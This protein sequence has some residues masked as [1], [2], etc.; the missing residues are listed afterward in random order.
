MLLPKPFIDGLHLIVIDSLK[1]SLINTINQDSLLVA[2]AHIEPRICSLA[3]APIISPKLDSFIVDLRHECLNLVD[4]K[5][6]AVLDSFHPDQDST[7]STPVDTQITSLNSKK[8]R[9]SD[10]ASSGHE[11]ISSKE[12]TVLSLNQSPASSI[13][14]VHEMDLVEEHIISEHGSYGS[15]SSSSSQIQSVYKSDSVEEDTTSQSEQDSY[16]TSLRPSFSPNQSVYESDSVEEDTTSQSEH[17]AYISLSS[18]SSP[19]QSVYES[20]LVDED[21]TNNSEDDSYISLS[22]TFSPAS[23]NQSVY[24]SYSVL[25][26]DVTNSSDQ[27]SYTSW[28]SDSSASSSNQLAYHS[29]SVDQGTTSEDDSYTSVSSKYESGSVYQDIPSEEGPFTPSSSISSSVFNSSPSVPSRSQSQYVYR[30]VHVDF[31]T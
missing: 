30:S 31:N 28:S 8:R 22:S 24:G 11:D 13:Q 20:D 26:E 10:Y 17:D 23:S 18:S 9:F 15:M 6:R 4:Q 25:D 27:E 21:T 2:F 12:D 7:P 14:C 19:N 1:E 3:K 5:L 16:H 29:G